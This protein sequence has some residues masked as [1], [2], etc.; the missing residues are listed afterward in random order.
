VD[1]R[2]RG[3]PGLRFRQAQPIK[4]FTYP[5]VGIDIRRSEQYEKIQLTCLVSHELLN[6]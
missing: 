4:S 5:Y 1:I 3:E 2:Q 6:I